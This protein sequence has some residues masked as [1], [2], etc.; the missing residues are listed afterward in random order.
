MDAHEELAKDSMG[1]TLIDSDVLLQHLRQLIDIKESSKSQRRRCNFDLT[2]TIRVP[3]VRP[4]GSHADLAARPHRP[5]QD[6]R[7]S[8]PRCNLSMLL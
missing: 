1:N 6:D 2:A 7:K 8:G 3:D 4:P 5:R